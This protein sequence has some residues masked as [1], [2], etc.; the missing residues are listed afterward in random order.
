MP[1]VIRRGCIAL[2]VTLAVSW[3]GAALAQAAAGE[4]AADQVV[5]SGDV[6]VA[7]GTVVDEVVVFSGSASIDGVAQGDVVVLDGPVTIRG[8][9]GGDV[10]ALHGPIR[11]LAT[12]QVT[13]NV[14][15][16]GNLIVVDGAQVGGEVRRDVGFTLA[17]PVGVLGAL[18]ISAAMAISILVVGLFLVLLAP[19][20]LER[21]ATAARA[22]P[23]VVAGWGMAL[24]VGVP[25]GAVV[26]AVT[27]VGL[28]LGLALL[29]G[30]GLVWLCGQAA[31]TYAVG[32]LVVR[33]PR[34][35]V[36]ALFAGWAIGAAVGL[37]PFLNAVWWT[38]GAMFGLGAVL[39][40]TWRARRGAG[41]LVP[42][43][44]AGRH[45]GQGRGTATPPP[46]PVPA[47]TVAVD[48]PT[49]MPLAED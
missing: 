8:Q 41:P 23:F 49:D 6:A 30:L 38:L 45:M 1:D 46:A 18:L 44:R 47:E 37:V 32:R 15:A 34:S 35:R 2:G 21:T 33:A 42:G 48:R 4:H 7:R 22:T 3:P 26:S 13:G 25:I 11:L 12:A 17:G 20:G 5:L 29:L 28:P 31:V 40:A 24:A 39:V 36:G 14:M 27:I 9:V 10:I 16:G 19:R 43:G